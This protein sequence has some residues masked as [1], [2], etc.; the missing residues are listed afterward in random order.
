MSRPTHD[1]QGHRGPVAHR[2]DWP[3]VYSSTF[4]PTLTPLSSLLVFDGLGWIGAASVLVP[5]A[6]VSTGRLSGTATSFRVFNIAGGILLMLN[7][8]YHTAY[9]SLAVNA[10]WIVIGLYAM[11]RG[12]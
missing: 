2:A 12:R 1:V 10:L 4:I 6:L 11:T 3:L 9:P 7:A 5:Y 8:W